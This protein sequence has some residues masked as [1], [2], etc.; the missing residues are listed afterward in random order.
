MPHPI[1]VWTLRP[2]MRRHPPRF[3]DSDP[4]LHALLSSESD[5]RRAVLALLF[6]QHVFRQI[7]RV[8]AAR[9]ARSQIARD[10]WVDVRLDVLRRIVARLDLLL[11]DPVRDRL[12]DLPAYV[13]AVSSTAFDDMVRRDFPHRAKLTNRIR[14]VL[15][16]DARFAEWTAG[17]MLLTGFREWHGL[18]AAVAT[19]DSSGPLACDEIPSALEQ[20]FAGAGGP[21]PLDSVVSLL[22]TLDADR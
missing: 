11:R 5:D 16:H 15:R 1:A 14:Y 9:F 7:D 10:P 19:P 3:V 20:L 17:D 22:R 13:I 6:D 2:T 4:L 8:L 18:G 12:L 21:L